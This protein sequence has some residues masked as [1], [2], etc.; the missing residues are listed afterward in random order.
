MTALLFF[1]IQD[2]LIITLSR[3]HPLLE[4]LWFRSAIVLVLLSVF[5]LIIYGPGILKGKHHLFLISRGA[6]AFLAF[7]SYYIA[8]RSVPMADA[9]A[10]YMTAPLFVTI[11]SVPILGEKVGAHR[12]AAVIIGFS[13]VVFM[14][15]PGSSL[16]RLD[17][18]IP[19]FSALCYAM[20]PI[21][22]RKIG[23][24]EHPLTM[25]IY[26][27]AT[28]LVL[29]SLTSLVVFLI[30]DTEPG[31]FVASANFMQW[32]R[33]SVQS[34]LLILLT[35]CIF[36]IGLL[37]ITQA[38]RIAIVSSVAPFE[39]SYLLW[40]SLIGYLVFD[41]VPGSRMLLGGSIVVLCGCYIVLREKQSVKPQ[42]SD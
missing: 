31:S 30:P 35:G 42:T 9:A 38:Y 14:L 21:I 16:F 2:S 7:T 37:C 4:V 17:S 19:L 13:A 33:F 5:G 15:N 18:A 29:V 11:L 26:T 10:V 25:T 3:A 32:S 23:Q 39:Y 27:T 12:W 28:Y 20:I 8:L 1:A 36:S 6:L 40:A 34:L 24:T 41:D 22:N